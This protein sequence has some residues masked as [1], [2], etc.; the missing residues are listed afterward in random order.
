MQEIKGYKT[1]V[2]KVRRMARV[3]DGWMTPTTDDPRDRESR[4]DYGNWLQEE[5]EGWEQ[6][7]HFGLKY[8]TPIGNMARDLADRNGLEG[9]YWIEIWQN[10]KDEFWEV[11]A[12]KQQT[13][14]FWS[15]NIRSGTPQSQPDEMTQQQNKDQ[16]DVRDSHRLRESDL[17]SR[18]QGDE[19][20][21]HHV[22]HGHQ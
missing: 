22:A 1:A 16:P 10:L 11:W 13:D 3:N 17:Q 8:G 19:R 21:V 15:D 18:P 5:I 14:K 2:A 12:E 7:D 6:T 4:T 9:E 20:P